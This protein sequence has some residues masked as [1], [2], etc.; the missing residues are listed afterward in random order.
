[1]NRYA[2]LESEA[3]TLF[4][5]LPIRGGFSKSA[6]RISSAERVSGR[7]AKGTLRRSANSS[8]KLRPVEIYTWVGFQCGMLQ[9]TRVGLAIAGMS[10]SE[11]NDI[12]IR[13]MP[14]RSA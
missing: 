13:P 5:S 10:S 12:R 9:S 4:R 1:M 14:V 3:P 2:G 8:L 11:P 6:R 7:T